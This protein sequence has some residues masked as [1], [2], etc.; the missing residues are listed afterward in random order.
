MTSVFKMPK[1]KYLVLARP[2]S[3]L[4][5]GSVRGTIDWLTAGDVS[6]IARIVSNSSKKSPPEPSAHPVTSSVST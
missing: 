1:F 5:G 3:R 2:S 4:L 6:L